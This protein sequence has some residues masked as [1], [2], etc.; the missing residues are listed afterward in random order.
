MRR[1]FASLLP[2]RAGR[3]DL[4]DDVVGATWSPSTYPA[5]WPISLL[6]RRRRWGFEQAIREAY[7]S[8]VW[9]YK[10]VD[11]IANA[12]ARLPFRF[13]RK[14][15]SEVMDHHPLY[16][17]LDP[18]GTANPLENGRAFRKRLSSQALLSPRGAFIEL[19]LTN[20]GD[21]ARVDLLPPSRTRPVPPKQGSDLIDHFEVI[22]RDGR[23]RELPPEKVRW[24]RN[25]HPADPYR[26][27][28][29]LDALGA[30]V[31][32]DDLGRAV[33]VNWMKNDG[34][35]K[36]IVAVKGL[37]GED[38]AARI[39][40][41]FGRGPQ[42][43]G[44]LTVVS[45]EALGYQDLSA[46]SRDMQYKDLAENSKL[47]ILV[48]FGVP[49]SQIGNASNRKY[50]NAE[51]EGY[52]FWSITMADHNSLI[53]AAF[54]QEAD[55]GWE[56]WL[57]VSGVEALQL[58][59]RQRREE[60]RAEFSAGLRTP[61]DYA[62]VAGID[63]ESTPETRALWMPGAQR[64]I[65]L[66][67]DQDRNQLTPAAAPAANG[68][69]AAQGEEQQPGG[70][71]GGQ[72]QN[73]NAGGGQQQGG[74]PA[75]A[76]GPADGGGTPAPAA[77]GGSAGGGPADG[78]GKATGRARLRLIGGYEVKRR[79]PTAATATLDVRARGRA[80]DAAAGALTALAARWQQRTL[81]RLRGPK[82]RKGTRHWAPDPRLP[83]D[84]R[85]GTKVLDT[86]A[87]VDPAS[88][89]Q[90][91]E[92]TLGPVLA[93]AALEQAT[94]TTTD[95][96]GQ[97]PTQDDQQAQQQDGRHQVPPPVA[98]PPPLLLPWGG[99]PRATSSA[100]DGSRGGDDGHGG[101]LAGGV[102]LASVL[103]AGA[104]AAAGPVLAAAG[105]AAA[106]KAVALARRLATADAQGADLDALAAIV[107]DATL[108]GWA[109]NLGR[110]IAAS[111]VEAGRHAAATALAAAGWQV[112]GTWQTMH[113]DHV[114]P[115]H[116][117]AQD[118][119]QA[120]GTPFLVG[121]TLLR[122]PGD[123]AGPPGEVIGCRCSVDW[124]ATQ[125][126]TTKLA[127]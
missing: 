73:G 65:Y 103:A 29:P 115:T 14:D 124:R 104:A 71:Q 88:W 86:A 95:L 12:E 31:E 23:I 78:G 114:R 38:D 10:A 57:D 72:Q 53:A 68:T 2:V 94:A 1:F 55:A 62:D 69:T 40:A 117:A 43:A 99:A 59:L 49:E 83:D 127:S 22:D 98:P 52:S 67:A 33:N 17:V 41:R 54:S 13:K 39:E 90:E 89:Q 116:R 48:G 91:L 58:P 100:L 81:T 7:E 101:L 110:T 24:V 15:S 18:D 50:S 97:P 4:L 93:A 47:E 11:T 27:T 21:I 70:Q 32:M 28:V 125:P 60:A 3:K 102:V 118:Q 16:D 46:H 123:P 82:A 121:D 105:A 51:Q 76:G 109:D 26:A 9:V 87:V 45:A 80:E 36:G 34:A 77:A 42:D 96:T 75:P 64:P 92:A 6:A 30:S 112:A 61:L 107:E 19:T 66:G 25:P 85:T 122:Y 74:Q 35:S 126:G 56:P 84:T 111:S 108:P 119:Q 8:S 5:P 120:L 113:D 37:A 63:L 44:K 106:A 79:A 20:G